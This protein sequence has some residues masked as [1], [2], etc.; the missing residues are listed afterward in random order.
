MPYLKE[1]Q[2]RLPHYDYSTPEE[3]F[4]TINIKDRRPLFGDVSNHE[5]HLSNI[6]RIIKDTWLQIPKQ[7]PN[8]S[9]DKWVIMPDHFHG[10]VV[11]EYR[12]VIKKQHRK[13]VINHVPTKDHHDHIP[14]GTMYMKH[15]TLGYIIRWFKG[16]STH[17]IHKERL[18]ID[19]IWQP[20][21]HDRVI[22]D[23]EELD[24]IREYIQLNPFF[25]KE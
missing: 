12:D 25:W 11:L 4:V 9:L 17:L 20:R 14:K 21:F 23:E 18:H 7:L 24:N 1:K 19:P 8:V 22:R 13:N 16:R 5:M 6:G 10:I 2:F 15:I 3:Y